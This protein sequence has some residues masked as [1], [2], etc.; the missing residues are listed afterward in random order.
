[1]K[2]FRFQ[3]ATYRADRHDAVVAGEE[4]GVLDLAIIAI[5][6]AAT[7]VTVATT[8]IT[9]TAATTATGWT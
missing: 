4:D 1:M 8:T 6:I 3:I 5:A 2:L 7:A 9:T